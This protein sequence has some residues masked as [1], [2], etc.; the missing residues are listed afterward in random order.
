MRIEMSVVIALHRK[1]RNVT[2]TT[3]NIEYEMHL[4]SNLDSN[5]VSMLR[6]TQSKCVLRNICLWLTKFQDLLHHL[7]RPPALIRTVQSIDGNIR[8]QPNIALPLTLCSSFLWVCHDCPVLH[9]IPTATVS[10]ALQSPKTYLS[11]PAMRLC[12]RKDSHRRSR[13]TAGRYGGQGRACHVC[14]WPEWRPANLGAA[15]TAAST[16]VARRLTRDATSVLAA[17]AAM[18]AMQPESL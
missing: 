4:A 11:V 16:C 12:W 3:V 8:T 6:N 14:G 7:L 13:L 9:D 17:Q 10:G 18:A 15:T 2:T 1:V 5:Y